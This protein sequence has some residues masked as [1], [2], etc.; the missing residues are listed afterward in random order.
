MTRESKEC[1][2]SKAKSLNPQIAIFQANRDGGGKL[3][4]DLI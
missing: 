1:M 2:A 4:F 3:I